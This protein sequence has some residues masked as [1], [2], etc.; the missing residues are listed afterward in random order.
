MS[1]RNSFQLPQGWALVALGDVLTVLRGVTYK[2]EHT[3]DAPGN[4]LVPIL[5]ATNINQQ[6]TFDDLVYVPRHYVSDAQLLQAGDIVIAASSG[7]SSVVGKAAPLKHSWFGSFGAFCYCLRPSKQVDPMLIAYYLQTY[8]Y[9]NRVSELASGVNINNLRR[10]HIEETPLKLPP[11]NEQHRIVEEIEKQF[12]RLDE[13]VENLKRVQANLKRYRA[14]VLQAACEGRLVPTEAELARKESKGYEPADQL[15]QRIL[16]ERRKKWEENEL[17]KM[18][19]KGKEPKDDKWKSRYKEPVA[20][21]TSDLPKLPEGWCWTSIGQA[22]NVYVGATPSRQMSEYWGGDIPWVSS[23][24]VAFCRIRHTRESITQA[25]LCNSSTEIHPPGTV[26][27]GMIGEGKTRGQAAILDIYA[28]HSQNSASIRVSE[29]GIPPEYVYYFL[30]LQYSHTRGLGSG[31]SQPALNKARVQ[32]ILLPLPP[33]AEMLKMVT[34]LER[35]LSVIEQM[36]IAVEVNLKHAE[37]IR[38]AILKNAFEGK[39]LQQ[40]PNDEPASVLLERIKAERA[41]RQ[42]DERV[43]KPRVKRVRI[44]SDKHKHPL[45]DVLSEAGRPLTSE[46]LFRSAG[47]DA[48]NVLDVD[49]FFE[50]LANEVDVRLRIVEDKPNNTNRYLRVAD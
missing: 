22:F 44:M 17:A 41:L 31:N 30:E 10:N 20:P 5:R 38:Q 3:S 7:S 33:L 13:A 46:E 6:L 50:A 12:S 1:V 21:D 8:E 27:L 2:K 4:D 14:S 43:R 32:S 25:G 45:W 39:L 23:G 37:R 40:D 9:R 48:N 24:E 18:R 35:R 42:Q 16:I 15:L 34:E 47:Y 11:F 26:L 19:E 29:A 36:K 28:A 49:A